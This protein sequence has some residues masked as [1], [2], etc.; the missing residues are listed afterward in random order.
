MKSYFNLLIGFRGHNP[1]LKMPGIAVIYA[2]TAVTGLSLLIEY[3]KWPAADP[4]ATRL[5]RA[6]PC[7]VTGGG[8]SGWVG[9]P[10]LQRQ[11]EALLIH[12]RLPPLLILSTL[13]V[14]V[15]MSLGTR[16]P[17]FPPIVQFLECVRPA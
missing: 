7:I 8:G 16:A 1:R 6:N 4:R 10:G 15:P 14:G 5:L 12:L 3:A 9:Q 11:R 2:G 13:K 17:L